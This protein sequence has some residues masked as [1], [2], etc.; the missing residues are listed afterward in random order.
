[1]RLILSLAVVF[2]IG[3]IVAIVQPI[4]AGSAQ[5]FPLDHYYQ[6]TVYGLTFDIPNA[7]DIDTEERLVDEE[8]GEVNID[9]VFTTEE[10]KE[11]G[12]ALIVYPNQERLSLQ[13]WLDMT[14]DTFREKGT[15]PYTLQYEEPKIALGNTAEGIRVIGFPKKGYQPG[16]LTFAGNYYTAGD[17]VYRF[18]WIDRGSDFFISLTDLLAEITFTQSERR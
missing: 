6:N 8:T 15:F 18:L 11:G 7:W 14:F 13:D 4:E 16:Y 17:F 9:F 2:L 5:H 1:M 12:F 10:E 3:F